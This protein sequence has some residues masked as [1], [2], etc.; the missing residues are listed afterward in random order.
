MI[1]QGIMPRTWHPSV[2]AI[3]E[4]DVLALV[5]HAETVVASNVAAMP[6]HEEFIARHCAAP[7]D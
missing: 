3:Q 7:A 1:G 5:E 2:E 6:R 4:K